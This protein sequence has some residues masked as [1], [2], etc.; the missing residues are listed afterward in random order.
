M[1]Y[2]VCEHYK[3]VKPIE[4]F[5]WDV[6]SNG[7][8][9][10][11]LARNPNVKTKNQNEKVY[12]HEPYAQSLYNMYDKATNGKTDISPKDSIKGTTFEVSGVTAISDHEIA[13]DTLGG[14]TAVIDLNKERQYLEAIGC[15]TVS[16]FVNAI[17]HAPVFKKQF[18]ES[19]VVGKVVAG[20]RV[21][22]WEGHLS[23]IEKTFIQQISNPTA[24][25]KAY[26]EEINGGGY[27]VDIMGIKCFMP[28]SL[29]AAGILTD[30]NSLIGKTLPVMIVNHLPNSGFV[31]S[32]KKYLN[33]ILPY[34]IE[35]ELY[36]GLDISTKVTGTS[37]N[38][39]FVQFKDSEGEWIF[40][41]LI[42][43][44]VMSADFEKR[45]DRHEFRVGDE[46]RAY[47][48]NII[49]TEDGQ[50]RIV[51]SDTAPVIPE[52]DVEIDAEIDLSKMTK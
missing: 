30:F 42:H 51:V 50:Y 21:S 19:G 44:S 11:N 49:E 32:Y 29:A 27:I 45:F 12:C 16:Q 9:G 34:K 33:T 18:L 20:G 36:P 13:V 48:H 52:D 40:S 22:L 43:R 8:N 37:K 23:K 24:A 5:D 14:L 28:G 38:G 25:Y 4:D 17:H 3:N 31:V 46:F 47:V 2:T 26:V 35:N 6:Y 7:Y 41:G 39:V 10:S 1:G 15:S